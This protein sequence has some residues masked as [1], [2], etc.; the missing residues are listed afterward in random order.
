MGN[1]KGKGLFAKFLSYYKPYKGWFFLDMAM[2]ATSSV[3][4]II[5]PALVRKVLS[6]IGVEGSL[7]YIIIILMSLV[8]ACYTLTS[9]C[10]YIR[11]RWGHYLGVWIENDMRSDLFNH[12]Q[13][14]S[15]SYFDSHK[16]GDIMSRISNDLFNIAEVAHHGPED[17]VISILTIIGAYVLMFIINAPMS[18]ISIIPLPIMAV[19]G[20][21]FNKKLKNRNRA[22]RKSISEINVTAENSIQGIR[23]VK[24]FSQE[25][26]QEKKFSS[27]NEKLKSSREKMYSSMAQYNAGMEFMRQ[28]Y[29]FITICGGVVLIALGKMGVADLTT[30]IL[31]VSVVLPPIDRLINFTEQFTQGVASFERFEEIMETSPDI[32]DSPSAQN[33]VV[34]KGEIDYKDVSFS[35]SDG[36]EEIVIHGL[37]LHIP[38]GKKI[39]LVGESG[40]GKTT[41]VSLL[42]R[43]YER[44][45]GSITIDGIDINTVTQESLHRAIGFVQQSIFLFDAS[46]REN[47]RYGKPDAKDDE[48]WDALEKANLAE[49]VRTLPDGLDT[50]VG[51]HGTRLSGGQKQRL[52]IARVFLKNP[53]ILVFDE[54]TSSLDTESE[55][56]ISSAFNTLSKGRTSIIIAHRLSTV[57]DS[58]MIFVLDK[59]RVVENGT[60]QE[61]MEKKGLYYKLYSLK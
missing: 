43:F 47:L 51:E 60:H 55:T 27:S 61:L 45:G 2:A 53:P 3:L 56:L 12:L 25:R 18:L 52:S 29:Y 36:E 26:F 38:G 59:G 23:E 7:K 13:K 33:L 49:F 5:S 40:A 11:I 4:S 15:F 48:L 22:I 31:Y 28:L 8:F 41:T 16:T 24:S 37:D 21:V 10:T 17:V 9:V 42:A 57:I 20:I 44:T 58:D 14:L 6:F 46:I 34:T 1:N 50:Q 30:F 32:V 19:Y 54:A 39:A 35:Y